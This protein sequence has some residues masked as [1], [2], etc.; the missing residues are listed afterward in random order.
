MK[1]EEIIQEKLQLIFN[2]DTIIFDKS[3]SAGGLTN[4]N[5]IMNIKGEEYVVRQPGGMTNIMIDRNIEK[6]NNNIASELGLNSECVYFDELSGIKISKYIKDSHNVALANPSCPA[7]LIAVSKLMKKIHSSPK[8]FPNSFDWHTELKKY[9][10]I[11]KE[12][13]GDLFFDYVTL[14]EKL[15]DFMGEN[16]KHIISLP[17]HN[18]TVP[19]N[20]IIN[21]DGRAFLIDWEYSGMNDPS[22]DVAAYILEAKLTEESIQ[23]LVLEYYGQIPMPE[24]VLKLKCFMI[25][26]DLLWA[27]W[28]LIRHYNGDDFLDYCYFRYERFRKNIKAI[29]VSLD[30][31]IG[32]LV[33]N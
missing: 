1:I 6:V 26:Q 23:Y 5:Y 12:L 18:D 21:S 10:Q 3:R 16:I 17:C 9:E 8:H 24:E 2:D 11:V 22:W 33:K 27:V 30:Y 28:A 14:K 7:N 4:Y 20:F 13:N 25:A 19:E 32:D 31:S 29:T 15:L